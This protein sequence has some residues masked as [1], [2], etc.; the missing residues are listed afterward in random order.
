M[1]ERSVLG[2]VLV[3]ATALGATACGDLEA[4]SGLANARSSDEAVAREVLDAIASEDRAA[5][6]RL[7]ITEEEHRE[8][9]WDQLPEKSTWS[10]DY[11]RWLN[12]HN[13]RKAITRAFEKWG[14]TEFQLLGIEYRKGV[15]EY[16]GF[17]LHRG[18]IL[19]VRR[20]AD[21]AE[22]TMELL[23]VLVERRGDWKP[24][25]YTE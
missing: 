12:E 15:E 21:G 25:N 20:T 5:M 19:H 17:T 13:T 22:G 6:E 11:V 10:F 24:M 7:L 8:L 1:L 23:D 4:R 18:A 9:L 2:A 14:G 3:A 16:D